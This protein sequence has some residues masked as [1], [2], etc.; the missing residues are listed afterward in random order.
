MKILANR[1]D[2][3]FY[4]H[5]AEYETAALAVLRSGWYVLG[6]NVTQ[7]EDAFAQ[8][9]ENTSMKTIMSDD[10]RRNDIYCA[11]L[12]SGLDALWIGIKLL[13]I[14]VGDEV[15]VQGNTYI[16][17]V[18]GITINEATPVF[19][20]SD[21]D[22]QIDVEQIEE[23]ITPETKA[24][25]VVHLYGQV[26]DMTKVVEICKKYHLRLIEDC[27]QAHGATWNEQKVGTFGDI[28]CFSFYP[29]KNI[30]AFGDAGAIISHDKNLIEEVKVFRNYGSEKKY[31]NKM[32]GANS[33]L[34][35][36][37][38][39]LL[40][41]RLK[42]YDEITSGRR[43]I[44]KR[45]LEGITNPNIRLPRERESSYAV[46]HQFV[47]RC[48]MRDQLKKYLEQNEIGSMIHYPI[49]P[50]KQEAYRYLRVDADKYP[51][52]NR[53]AEEVLSIPIYDG[54]TEEEQK[55]VMD[56][57]NRFEG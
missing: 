16:A 51:M 4:K 46:W 48:R 39:A 28:G 7:F 9:H 12:A 19:V 35:E 49:P 17:S 57:I 31:Y 54:M 11:S 25:M 18:M 47:I 52:T 33:R 24:V 13:G 29:T 8:F 3:G 20:D 42:Y 55:Y 50:Y 36:I 37:Q 30:G 6:E 38:A 34:D 26:T 45:Y 53:L 44:A 43:K 15:I 1:M 27:A 23:A 56:V 2:V 14:G 10:A 5:Q 32:V 22:G 41:I 21:D 40:Q